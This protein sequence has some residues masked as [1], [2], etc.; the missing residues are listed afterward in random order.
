MDTILAG[1]RSQKSGPMSEALVVTERDTG[2]VEIDLVVFDKNYTPEK[3]GPGEGVEGLVSRSF[4]TIP[5]GLMQ[6]LVQ[7]WNDKHPEGVRDESWHE[8]DS[9]RSGRTGDSLAAGYIESRLARS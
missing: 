3:H 8:L 7:R 1:H 5:A 4:I 9:V 6:Q 2:L